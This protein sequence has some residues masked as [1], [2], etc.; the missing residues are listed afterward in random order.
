MPVDHMELLAW[1]ADREDTFPGS[2]LDGTT[3]MQQAS[4]LA[5]SDGLPWDAVARATGRLRKLGLIDWDYTLWPNETQEPR[6]DF[7]DQQLLQRTRNIIVTGHGHEALAARGAKVASTQV[8]IVNSTVGQLALGD[9]RNIDVFVIL[10]AADQALER[11]DASADAKSEARSAIR[12]MREAG[13]S[14]IS[15]TAREV[16]AAAVRQALGLP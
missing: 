4:G 9:I 2:W 13:A 15:S 12:R 11:L 1:I 14:A 10:D 5:G 8:N 7:I 3:L 6:P 16:L